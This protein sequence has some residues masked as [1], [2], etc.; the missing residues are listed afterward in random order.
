MSLYF[1]FSYIFNFGRNWTI[2]TERVP[3]SLDENIRVQN[4]T[5]FTNN[6]DRWNNHLPNV[7][8]EFHPQIEILIQTQIKFIQNR[9]FSQIFSRYWSDLSQLIVFFTRL[10]FKPLKINHL[11][12]NYIWNINFNFTVFAL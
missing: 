1:Y 5:K 12:V 11:K 10:N 6:L 4:N 2:K 8:L 3:L 7:F 9:L